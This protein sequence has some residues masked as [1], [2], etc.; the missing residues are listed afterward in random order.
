[1]EITPQTLSFSPDDL[2]Q[3]TDLKGL[4]QLVMAQRDQLSKRDEVLAQRDHLIQQ[5]DHLIQQRDHLIQQRDQ[6]IQLR[7]R[8]IDTLTEQLKRLRHLKFGASSERFDP[9][10]QALF[11]E[12]LSAD[13]AA[14]EAEIEA[15]L[16]ALHI[17]AMRSHHSEP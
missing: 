5:R 15:V 12:T 13:I 6:T 14:V 9:S 8:L 10:Q 3:M 2:A 4:R 17:P 11:E 7:D 16:A 1:M